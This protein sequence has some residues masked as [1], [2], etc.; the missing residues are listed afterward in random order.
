MNPVASPSTFIPTRTLRRASGRALLCLGAAIVLAGCVDGKAD[1]AAPAAVEVG[2]VTVVTQPLPLQTELAGRT[3]AAQSA[4]VRPQVTALVRKRLFTEGSMVK[5]GQPLYQLD[6]TSA[7]ASLRVAGASVGP[8]QGDK[9]AAEMKA[10]RQKTPAITQND[11][12]RVMCF[13]GSRLAGW[14]GRN[15]RTVGLLQQPGVSWQRWMPYG[16]ASTVS[17]CLAR[18]PPGVT[19][20]PIRPGAVVALVALTVPIGKSAAPPCAKAVM[21][22]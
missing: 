21:P 6:S 9:V 11:H 3:V 14:I 1:G 20:A 2:V 12:A 7:E 16:Q 19:G 5:A 17:P 18:R 8:R 15:G 10:A 4:E 13:D 22:G